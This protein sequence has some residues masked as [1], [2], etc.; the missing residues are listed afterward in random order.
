MLNIDGT[1]GEGGGQILRSSLALAAVTGRAFVIDRIRGKRSKPGLQ[2]QHLTSVKAA[3][4]VCNARVHGAELGS[5]S[6]RFEPG[7]VTHGAFHLAIGTAGSTSLVLQ[8]M[9]PPLLVTEGRSRIVL[10][11]GTHNPMAPTFEFLAHSF[12][13][14]LH[15]MGVGVKAELVRHGFYPAGGGEVV[16][17]VSGARVLQPMSLLSC[18]AIR[19]VD[20][21]AV[22]AQIPEHVGTREANV[23]VGQLSDYAVTSKVSR[24]ASAGPGNVVT[25]SVRR[26]DVTE[27][28]TALGEI[29]VRA[30][31]VAHRLAGEVRKYLDADVP[32]GEHLA[33]QLLLPMALAGQGTL[34]TMRPSLHT[35]TN[36]KVIEMFLPVRVTFEDEGTNGCLI[37]VSKSG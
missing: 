2:R 20:V 3:A 28:F 9:L 26:D 1:L 24:V 32:V 31:T 18:S 23:L 30:E 36:A 25:V 8:A 5:Q 29:G 21:H 34:R 17:E 27:T 35:E 6:L 10:E 33:D 15:R 16:F 13:P 11:G 14:L 4:Q 12:L 7:K 37:H 19:H 22:T